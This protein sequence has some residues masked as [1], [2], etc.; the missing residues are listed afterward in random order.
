MSLPRQN[1]VEILL[2][3]GILVRLG[4]NAAAGGFPL[5]K[6]PNFPIRKIP[7]GTAMYTKYLQNDSFSG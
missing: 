3:L 1:Y 6:W 7:I 2:M 4:S 5:G